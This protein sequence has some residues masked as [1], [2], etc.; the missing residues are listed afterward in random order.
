M[1]SPAQINAGYHSELR[2]AQDA[3]LASFFIAAWATDR[4]MQVY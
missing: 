2:I 3:A 1:S 4:P